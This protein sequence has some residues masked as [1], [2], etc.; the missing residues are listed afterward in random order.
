MQGARELG[1][2]EEAEGLKKAQSA[3]GHLADC[4]GVEGVLKL[5]ADVFDADFEPG[6]P[7]ILG[8]QGFVDGPVNGGDG[9]QLMAEPGGERGAQA[10]VP[11]AAGDA[12]VGDEDPLAYAVADKDQ[13][14]H[15]DGENGED[16]DV[17]GLRV[18]PRREAHGQPG[19]ESR[20]HQRRH[21]R[22]VP[23]RLQPGPHATQAVGAAP[24]QEAEPGTAPRA[25]A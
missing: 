7:A 14:R 15:D 3:R 19:E 8:G 18:G 2:A 13:E 24:C 21:D 22:A 5:L 6:N 4:S 12:E 17:P 20:A 23:A 1:T 11:T 16:P 9:R 25:E 10:L